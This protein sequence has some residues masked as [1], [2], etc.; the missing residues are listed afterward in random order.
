MK[1]KMKKGFT[2]V[3]LLVVIAILAILSTVAIVGYN[4]FT[5]KA[6]ISNDKG[7]V[8]QLN[9]LLQADEAL[10]GKAKTPTDAL[11]VVAENG[12]DVKKM[13]PT[14]DDYSIVWNEETNRFVLLDEN[15]VA[16]VEELSASAHKNWQFSS[17]Y[18]QIV[19]GF[20]VCLNDNFEGTSLTVTSGLDVGSNV[21]IDVVYNGTAEVLIRTN[22]GDLTVN[23]GTVN[24]YGSAY[25]LTVATGASYNEFGTV[26]ANV[27]DIETIP[28]AEQAQW[29][30]VA[31]KDQLEAALA[32][33]AVEKVMLTAD[34]NADSTIT[35]SN[36]NVFEVK[37]VKELNLNGFN[38]S[39]EVEFETYETAN[40][41][42]INVTSGGDLTISGYGKISYKY[43][44]AN[45]GWTYLS[46]V[47][48][49]DSSSSNKITV[50]DS[51]IIEHLGG[52]S[53][54]YG[55]DIYGNSDVV[56]EG[57]A[58][59]S[60]YIAIRFFVPHAGHSL[61][62]NAGLISG[63]KADVWFHTGNGEASTDFIKIANGISFTV[64]EPDTESGFVG[65]VRYYLD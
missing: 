36:P 12:F 60:T 61:T 64:S 8:T 31:N 65:S 18:T 42:L 7:L 29:T 2:L 19:D 43:N 54:S 32:D 57:G 25:Y 46:A 55:I 24:H 35:K 27:A 34:I 53:M 21:G 51:V 40:N 6:R 17:A 48:R 9:T 37:G 10:D 23:S 39:S 47:V 58:I 3:E 15:N 33:V 56:I 44:S 41:V 22:N 13:T 30:K 11:E 20:S 1:K 63:A 4:S 28:E 62:I 5:E 49:A 50:K 14:A 38:I 16:V 45:M 26:I 52:T 59:F